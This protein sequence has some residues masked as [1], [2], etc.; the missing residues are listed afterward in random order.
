MWTKFALRH[1]ETDESAGV[2]SVNLRFE[3]IL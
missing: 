3:P 2:V 1:R